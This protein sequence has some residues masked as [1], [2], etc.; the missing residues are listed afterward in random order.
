MKTLKLLF[1]ILFLLV[2]A[3]SIL[4]FV[5]NSEETQYTYPTDQAMTTQEIV[6]NQE[7][8]TMEITD[9][10]MSDE[11]KQELFDEYRARE[12]G[13]AEYAEARAVAQGDND[14]SFSEAEEDRIEQYC[15]DEGFESCYNIQYTCEDKY[16]CYLVTITCED[17]DYDPYKEI[18]YGKKYGCD[19]WNVVVEENSFDIRDVEESYWSS[20]GYVW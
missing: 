6:T 10:G 7:D 2:V 17:Y 20:Y 3:L 15:D 11:E 8:T 13:A 4:L 9:Y 5:D 14:Q 19:D 16:E 18:Q 1:S 12:D